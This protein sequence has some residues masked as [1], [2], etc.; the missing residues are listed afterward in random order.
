MSE[1]SGA[2]SSEDWLTGK[3]SIVQAETF[4]GSS[5]Q[6]C[7]GFRTE[8]SVEGS[9]TPQM[10][11][12]FTGEAL[13]FA[14]YARRDGQWEAAIATRFDDIFHPLQGICQGLAGCIYSPSADLLASRFLMANGRLGARIYRQVTHRLSVYFDTVAGRFRH[15]FDSTHPDATITDELGTP[16]AIGSL[17]ISRNGRWLVV[18]HR[19]KGIVRVN[20]DDYSSR[21]VFAPGPKYGV[22]FDP[23]MELAVSDDG[24]L[25]AMAGQN[26]DFRILGI[27]DECGETLSPP[28]EDAFQPG[29][30]PC[31][32]VNIEIPDNVPDYRFS[33]HPVFG[34]KGD[35]IRFDTLS[36]GNIRRRIVVAP[37]NIPSIFQL[38]YL[39]LGDSF[40]SGEGE[41]SD[42]HYLRGTN[43]FPDICHVSDRSYPFLLARHFLAHNDSVKSVACSGARS[44][45]IATEVNYRGQN[46]RLSGVNME[47]KESEA[48]LNFQPGWVTQDRFVTAYRPRIITIGI[49]GN[50]VGFMDKLKACV[51]PG[52]CEWVERRYD[53]AIEIRNVF[54]SLV[55]LFRQL[56]DESPNS[57]LYVLGY[58]QI[59]GTGKCNASLAF[60][61][62][63]G[64]RRFMREGLHYLN[65][66]IRSAANRAKVMFID[67][68]PS[69]MGGRLCDESNSFEAV[70]GLRLGDDIAPLTSIPWLKVIGM[71]SFHPTPIGHERVAMSV[72]NSYPDFGDSSCE[73][74]GDTSVPPIP[75]YWVNEDMTMGPRLHNEDFLLHDVVT[76]GTSRI[77]IAVS[78]GAFAPQSEVRVELHSNHQLLGVVIANT[79]GGLDAQFELPD[80][81][82]GHHTVHLFGHTQAGDEVDIYDVIGVESSA[83]DEERLEAEV[84]IDYSKS[85]RLEEKSHTTSV[86][87]TTTSI[88]TPAVLG[89]TMQTHPLH[90]ARHVK[91]KPLY[92]EVAIVIFVLLGATVMT[93]LLTKYGKGRGG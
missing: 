91:N 45:D 26:I 17:A 27:R 34:Q 84:A 10:A 70:N 62:D 24:T 63:E 52:T 19:D 36:T 37:A 13:E 55:S 32:T 76:M 7:P 16:L 8:I 39:A 4:L 73:C 38:E 25:I 83:L 82:V 54:D 48:I 64:E 89:L 60:M 85:R 53:V 57:R 2:A 49:G 66:V 46:Q 21:R 35:Y 59:M 11:C 20:L 72:I 12:V 22:G 65:E 56:V 77:D 42:A 80:V 40:S 61:L 93:I 67:V 28:I 50:D 23:K 14:T 41:V 30:L 71:E 68:E 86:V 9:S 75:E 33:M 79:R 69:F 15:T 31:G 3:P 58:P 18:E 43:S 92:H 1:G 47:L 6:Y 74:S 88:L 81:D 90:T 5:D 87:H 29:T 78:S 51:M 44:R